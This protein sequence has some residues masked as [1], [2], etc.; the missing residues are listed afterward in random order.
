[1]LINTSLASLPPLPKPLGLS[2]GSF[3]GLHR[4]HQELINHLRRSITDRGTLAVLTFSNHPNQVLTHRPAAP[5]IVSLEHKLQLLEKLG[6][7]LVF[8][9]EF[10]LE[11]AGQSYDQFLLNIRNIF[12]FSHLVL[13]SGAAFG[14]GQNG[15]ASELKTLARHQGFHVEYVDKLMDEGQ[16]ISSG[17]IRKLIQAKDFKKASELLGRPYGLYGNLEMDVTHA[18][19]ATLHLKGICLPPAGIYSI[20]MQRESHSI[21]GQAIVDPTK[22]LLILSFQESVE[23]WDDLFVE[24]IL[25]E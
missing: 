16:P 21:E 17:R 3:D 8:L 9:L 5:L 4:G 6:V 2:I 12:P 7:N 23:D 1:M 10:S 13:G 25:L 19:Q 24:I 15:G 14:K 22:Q 20:K 11:L 18:H